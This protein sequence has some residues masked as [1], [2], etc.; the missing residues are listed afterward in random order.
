LFVLY[1]T[2]VGDH[3][4]PACLVDRLA[5]ALLMLRLFC[6]VLFWFFFCVF[7]FV[8]VFVFV[9]LRYFVFVSDLVFTFQST[10]NCYAVL[11]FVCDEYSCTLCGGEIGVSFVV[12]S[13]LLF[14]VPR[15]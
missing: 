8:F 9:S 1:V 13:H 14:M 4:K 12:Q 7:V 11:F 2:F 6:F 15:D 10:T 3:L 5:T